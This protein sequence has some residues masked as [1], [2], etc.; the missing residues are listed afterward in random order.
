[1][2]SGSPGHS[3]E[4]FLI[5]VQN[6]R[7]ETSTS[8]QTTWS[9]NQWMST[10]SLF[11]LTLHISQIVGFE[12]LTAVVM[13][14]SIFWDI[15]P[16]SPLKVNRRFGET[17]RLHLQGR[18]VSQKRNQSEAG[19]KQIR[20]EIFLR[21]FGWFQRNTRRYNSEDTNSSF[22]GLIL[23]VLMMFGS[24][25]PISSYRIHHLKQ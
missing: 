4:N 19:S 8:H 3:N 6:R 13:K 1:M 23:S 20:G 11:A 12:V 2:R 18:R 21:N 22:H 14:I 16:C 24:L 5:W 7:C 17:Y 10:M 25:L 9:E 15:T